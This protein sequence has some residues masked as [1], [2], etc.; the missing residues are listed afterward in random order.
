MVQVW[1]PV[2]SA[3]VGPLL[4]S[5]P[6]QAEWTGEGSN[7]LPQR[8]LYHQKGRFQ[9]VQPTQGKSHLPHQAWLQPQEWVTHLVVRYEGQHLIHEVDCRVYNP[10]EQTGEERKLIKTWWN[11][12]SS[13]A[14][15]VG[16]RQKMVEH[17]KARWV[18]LLLRVII[19]LNPMVDQQL[20]PVAHESLITNLKPHPS[21]HPSIHPSFHPSIQSSIHS[22]THI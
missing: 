10:V 12:Q 20:I 8:K 13:Q 5:Y 18:V 3:H 7:W 9:S 11:W 1:D 16:S 22:S 21:I 4:T 14:R 6:G 15:A 2:I 17:R 19:T